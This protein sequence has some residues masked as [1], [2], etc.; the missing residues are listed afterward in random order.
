MRIYGAY[1]FQPVKGERSKLANTKTQGF[2]ARLAGLSRE[3]QT[4]VFTLRLG[5]LRLA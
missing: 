2:P 3:I 4:A 1:R 5:I